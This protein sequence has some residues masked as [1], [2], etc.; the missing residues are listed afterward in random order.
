MT[1]EEFKQKAA[2]PTHRDIPSYF[3][4][5]VIEMDE[6]SND[7]ASKHY[8]KYKTVSNIAAIALSMKEALELMQKDI[9]CRNEEEEYYHEVFCYTI[10][11]KPLNAMS[12]EGEKLA[13][14]IYDAKGKLIDQ[15]FC[16]S[17]FTYYTSYDYYNPNETLPDEIFR[18]RSEEQIRFHRGDIV[19]VFSGDEVSLAIVVGTPLTTE[20]VWKKNQ[21]ETNKRG[22]DEIPYD[23]TDDSYT[24]IDG[25]G[26]EYHEH[27]PSTCLFAPHYHVPARLER[28]FK[29]YLE[30][31]EYYEKV[32]DCSFKNIE[33]IK[34]SKT[35]G[36]FSCC[37]IF[38]ASEVTSF[39]PDSVPTAECPYCHIDAVIGDASGFPIT[40][41]L[42]RAMR[43][44]WF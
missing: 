42:L 2:H 40:P 26:Y 14:W 19:E 18:G 35:C 4:I 31:A 3:Q 37:E 21:D 22:L 36:C 24:V 13:E 39:L 8:P 25:P 33:Q 20:F 15:T 1:Y 11:E 43:R 10:V 28:R 30:K 17:A 44:K 9:V 16:A 6:Y 32:H 34:K 38:P 23:E 5:K 27:I 7:Y 12:Y 29:G 41:Q